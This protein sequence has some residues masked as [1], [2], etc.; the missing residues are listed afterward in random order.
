MGWT[1]TRPGQK[2]VIR[3]KF[4][5]NPYSYRTPLYQCE[6]LPLKHMQTRVSWNGYGY[7]DSCLHEVA[8]RLAELFQVIINRHKELL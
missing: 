7:S 5:G 8:L 1:K 6:R 3:V 4:T 2:L